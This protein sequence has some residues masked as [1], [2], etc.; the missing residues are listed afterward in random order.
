MTAQ[1]IYY[2]KEK[3]L[4]ELKQ[5]KEMKIQQ[6]YEVSHS[7]KTNSFIIFTYDFSIFFN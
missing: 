4:S 2:F 5:I 6:I 3:H 7:V 1:S